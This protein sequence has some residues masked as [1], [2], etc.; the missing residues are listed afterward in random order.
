MTTKSSIFQR[1]EYTINGIRVAMLTAGQGEPLMF[2]HGGGTFHG[3]DFAVPW[4][5]KYKVIIPFHPGFG[6]LRPTIPRSRACM[7]MSCTISSCS[8]SWRSTR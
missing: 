4:A 1:E 8:I 6:E 3:F 7:T 5:S 2:W